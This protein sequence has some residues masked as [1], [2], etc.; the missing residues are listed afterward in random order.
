MA[1][2]REHQ[3]RLCPRGMWPRGDVGNPQGRSLPLVDPQQRR[4]DLDPF[5]LPAVGLEQRAV[6]SWSEPAPRT[7]NEV[8]NPKAPGCFLQDVLLPLVKGEEPQDC[9]GCERSAG[10]RQDWQA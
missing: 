8:L 2:P 4:T 6:V 5:C 3:T 10:T 7:H 1:K 9:V